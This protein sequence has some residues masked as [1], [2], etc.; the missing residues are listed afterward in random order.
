MN[1]TTNLIDV[2]ITHAFIAIDGGDIDEAE[3][4][5]DNLLHL[6]P[7]V[8]FTCG[9]QQAYDWMSRYLH[10]RHQDECGNARC[11]ACAA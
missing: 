7:D 8:T 1:T 4:T 3:A 6:F 2:L 9:Q 5:I 10:E 11:P